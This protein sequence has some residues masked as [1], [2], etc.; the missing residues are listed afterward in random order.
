[1]TSLFDPIR[2]G[3]IEL[4]N[5]IAM[6][7]LTRNRAVAGRVPSP[8]A[9]EYYRQRADAGLIVTEATQI[10][11]LGQGYLDTPGIYSREQVEGWKAVTRAVHERGGKI[12]V[13]LW[14]VGRISH[15]SLLPEGEVPV[16][17]SAITAKSKTFTRNGFEDVSAPRA[18]ALAELP[19]IVEQYRVAARNAIEAG[20][21]GVEVH[22]ANGYLLEQFLRDSTNHRTDAYGGSIENRARLLLEVM[23]AVT[24]EIGAGRTGLRLSPVTPANDAALDSDPQALFNHVAEQLAP[25]KLAFLHVI[26]GATG[27]PRDVAPFDYAALRARVKAPWIVNNGYDRDMAIEAVADGRADVVAFG[28]PFI[29]NPDLVQRLRVGAPFAAL[30]RDTLYGG[31]AKGYTDYPALQAP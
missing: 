12:V 28:R 27:G 7:P 21:D 30:D 25:L 3:D 10:S 29:S 17:P 2:L 18:L 20:F 9:V 11:P 22:G 16:A 23:R 14:H 31:G 15:V 13:Q 26:E 5:R 8:L 19:G 1:M 4:R 6:A 24:A